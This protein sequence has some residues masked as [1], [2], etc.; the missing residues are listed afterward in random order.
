MAPVPPRSTVAVS[1]F[2]TTSLLRHAVDAS[3]EV[4][5]LT[6]TS[7]LITYVNQQF[8]TVYGYDADEVVGRAT[9][10]ILKSHRLSS[11]TY[12]ALWQALTSGGSIRSTHVNRTKSGRLVIMDA[13]SSAI[14][15]DGRVVGYL[16]IQRDVTEQREAE[17]AAELA[18]VAI[19]HAPDAVCWF[20]PTGRIRYVNRM[21]MRLTGYGRDELR[22]RSIYDLVP[23]GT[24][25]WFEQHWDEM[26]RAGAIE[27]KSELVRQDGT[28]VPVEMRVT[29]VIFQQETYGC[30]LLRD[31]TDRARLEAELLQA[32]KMEAIGR[33]AGGLAH[34][35]N[36]L[37]TAISGYADL[38]LAQISD[39][40]VAADVREI[41]NAVARASSLTRQLLTFSRRQPSEPQVLDANEAVGRTLRMIARLVGED[42]AVTFVPGA[43]ESLVRIDP[44]QLD[45]VLFN[46]AIN[47]RDAM[48][49]GGRLAF[50]TRIIEPDDPV[51]GPGAD[52]SRVG[53]YVSIAVADTGSGIPVELQA[54]ILEPFFTTKPA[55]KGTGLGL[56]T[57]YGIVGQAG[58]F[59]TVD[60]E[61]GAGT[62]ISIH[63]P[64]VAAPEPV[65]AAPPATPR[66][67]AE[68][69][70][71]LLVEDDA[72]V[73]QVAARFLAHRG[74]RVLVAHD[75][76]DA[77]RLGR[78][79]PRPIDLLLSDIVMPGM[80]GPDLAQRIVEWRPSMRVLYVSGYTEALGVQP[81]QARIRVVR[82][83]FTADELA[84]A[85]RQTLD[86]N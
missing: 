31:V 58:G 83:P 4:V 27:L 82:K 19:E 71:V 5:F 6:D 41:H 18:H 77:L 24:R 81:E 59:L 74:Y 65:E 64:R 42:V 35:F 14:V 45:Q 72:N 44:G 32:Q 23:D 33:L 28:T 38:A 51:A 3:G 79:Y 2:A 49:K 40:A 37:L 34:D 48:P 39:R 67:A 10:R 80:N 16:A 46:L 13:T 1:S 55:G 75:V 36:N 8:T 62:T 70:T 63:L 73:R 30:A 12:Q 47:A 29:R 7:G 17:R 15:E 56:S 60:S 43:D 76:A 57:V 21:T 61:V 11:E 68:D 84:A 66:T 54:R 20:D 26:V 22:Q 50:S 25:D 69:A 86:A 52:A 9:P 78:T 53:P 85:V